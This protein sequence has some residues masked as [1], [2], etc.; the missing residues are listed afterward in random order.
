MTTRFAPFASKG[1]TTVERKGEKSILPFLDPFQIYK[2]LKNLGQGSSSTAYLTVKDGNEYIMRVTKKTGN[3]YAYITQINIMRKLG[4]HP[5]VIQLVDFFEGD[6]LYY[7]VLEYGRC[8][9]L[10]YYVKDDILS[11]GNTKDIIR[12]VARGLQHMHSKGIVHGDIKM[13]NIV[14]QCKRKGKDEVPKIIDFDLSFDTS[15]KPFRTE[16]YGTLN[17]MAP[18]ILEQKEYNFPVDVWALGVLTYELLEGHL[19]VSDSFGS[20]DE[21]KEEI[22]N[23]TSIPPTTYS[24]KE[25]IDFIS[26]LLTYS[27]HD[28]PTIDEVLDMLWLQ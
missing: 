7:Q 14:I 8:R 25:A 5:N 24:S 22:I 26:S 17:Y 18:E 12:G 6:K 3:T 23:M 16:K 19:P 9:D 10:D 1:N 15:I 11:E 2:P 27:M 21:I 20:D 4:D 28:R 13:Q